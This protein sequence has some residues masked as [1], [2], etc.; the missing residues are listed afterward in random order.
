M[1]KEYNH[2]TA[3]HYLA[4]RPALHSQILKEHLDNH[5]SYWFGLDVGSGIGH[6]SIALAEYCE[7]VVGV[8]PSQEMLS[9]SMPHP[10]VKYALYDCKHLDFENGYFDII[11]FAGSLHYAKSAQILDEV[12]RVSKNGTKIV[13]YDF[14]LLL[15]D[16]LGM[17][18]VE[19]NAMQKS[20]YDHQVDLSGLDGKNIKTEQR[21]KKS[22]T[23]EICTPDLAHLLLS[24]KD[25][26]HL[27]LELF[28]RED[29][30]KKV[31]QKLNSILTGEIAKIEAITYITIYNVMK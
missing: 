13:I 27:L 14:E 30:Y 1:T 7:N 16:I 6:S 10:R 24:S 28:G 22:V 26:Y 19:G 18:R 2:I 20:E 29:L 9:K 15:D 21:A 31:L 12:I 25:N 4:F 17:L 5:S 8:E 3:F 23:V 11:T